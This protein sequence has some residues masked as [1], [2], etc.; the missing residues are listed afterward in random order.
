MPV[1]RAPVER[2]DDAVA[3]AG[4]PAM[5]GA[6]LRREGRARVDHV[7]R[8]YEAVMQSETMM[9]K[10]ALMQDHPILV[11]DEDYE[12][13]SQ[14]RW[15]LYPGPTRRDGT[16]CHYALRMAR[17]PDG[18][19]TPQFLHRFVLDLAHGG[20]GD[21]RR[22]DHING[23]GLDCRKENLRFTEG[24]SNQHSTYRHRAGAVRGVHYWP[25]RKKPWQVQI[26]DPRLGKYASGRSKMRHLG[27]YATEAEALAVARAFIAERY[28]ILYEEVRC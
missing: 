25:G 9:K 19:W 7:W 22:V 24:S 17:R 14:Y 23:D 13:V 10:I 8:R 12:R 5:P 2:A 27:C 26:S 15:Y 4:V 16:C 1:M 11:D 21:P 28:A 6:V 20:G 3:P 18:R